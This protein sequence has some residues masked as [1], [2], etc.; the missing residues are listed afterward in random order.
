MKLGYLFL[1]LSSVMTAFFVMGTYV[2]EN[3]YILISCNVLA[4][5]CAGLLCASAL[6]A[7]DDYTEEKRAT[8][9]L[10]PLI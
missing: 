10:I 2:F 7:L 3:S 4:I 1:F 8:L 9:A 5:L 6:Y